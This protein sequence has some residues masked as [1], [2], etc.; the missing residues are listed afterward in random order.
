VRLAVR[1]QPGARRDALLARL[2]DGTWKVAVAAPAREGRANDAV[3]RL[4]SGLL[5]IPRR[6]VVVARGASARGK[7]IDIE[8]LPEAE[9]HARLAAALA[10]AKREDEGERRGE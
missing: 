5:G 4:L 9:A 6:Q 10:G 8:G 3:V 2:A 7:W 1:V